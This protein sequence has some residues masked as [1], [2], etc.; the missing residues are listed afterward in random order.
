MHIWG[1]VLV[2]ILGIILLLI[3]LGLGILAFK[4]F[5]LLAIQR[6]IVDCYMLLHR[7]LFNQ[8]LSIIGVFLL[9]VGAVALFRTLLPRGRFLVY[10]TEEGE[11]KVS[12]DS[13]HSLAQE[14]LRGMQEI[15]SVTPQ[16]EKKGHNTR[17]FLH[18]VVRT[19]ASIPEL[20]SIVQAKVRERI[21]RQ[22]GIALDDVK[23]IVDLQPKEQAI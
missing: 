13:L 22:T 19:D 3:A 15:V 18:L 5:P 10:R 12:F 1:K 17:L 20:S 6:W 4:V 2:G 9:V 14:A 23:L 16:V 8:V 11:I 21:E 7:S